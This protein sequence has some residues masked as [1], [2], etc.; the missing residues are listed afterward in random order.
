MLRNFIPSLF[1]TCLLFGQT[2]Y[3]SLEIPYHIRSVGMSGSGVGDLLAMDVSS[4]NPALLS[5]ARKTLVV[6]AVR[7]PAS[8]QS[9]YVEWRS[10]W[11]GLHLSATFRGVSY[12]D[13]TERDREGGE[14]EDFSAGDAWLSFAMAK[15]LSTLADIGLSAGLFQSRV[16]DVQ[17]MLGLISIGGRVTIPQFAASLGVSVRNLGTTAESYTS[18][19]EEIPTSVAIG[20][21]RRMA[22]L[23]LSLSLDGVWWK[24]RSLFRIGGEFSLSKGFF[25]QF[26]S[27]SL[28]GD[29]QT[30]ELWR[31]IASGVSFGFGYEM[32]RMAIGFA[33]GNSGVGG[34]S[35]GVGF[36]RNF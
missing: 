23:P 11:K 18:H 32:P 29:L 24:E 35:L 22:Y 10:E 5:G 28:R 13:F 19:T 34:A 14:L 4:L 26:G 20:L 16:G 27:S 31:D 15:K 21:T 12:G 17:A 7:Y 33:V 9:Q 30:G 25:L 2:A 1:C 6:S 8:I 3:T 36:S